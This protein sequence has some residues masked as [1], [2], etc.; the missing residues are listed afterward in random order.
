MATPITQT[1]Q[2]VAEG[3][4]RDGSVHYGN[5]SVNHE[6]LI[7][8]MDEHFDSYLFNDTLNNFASLQNQDL[9]ML[10]LTEF[11]NSLLEQAQ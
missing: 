11:D 7:G 5:N 4:L 6:H 2:R 9:D 8:G 3:Q 1:E 10:F